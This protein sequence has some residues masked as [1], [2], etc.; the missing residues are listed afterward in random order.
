MENQFTR[1]E[2][3]IGTDAVKRLNLTRVAVFGIGGV[4]GYVVEA[5]A[6]T[7]VG[8]LT[9]VDSDTVAPSNLNRQLIALH[10]TLGRNKVDIYHGDKIYQLK[11]GKEL[12]AVKFVHFYNRYRNLI[13]GDNNVEFLGL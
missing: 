8:E 9:L 12:N 13:K 6:R 10:S 3:M 7:G 4:G 1:T 5:L 11:G 2:M